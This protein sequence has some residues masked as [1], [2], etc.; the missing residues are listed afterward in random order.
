[1]VLG[2][3]RSRKAFATQARGPEFGTIE[4]S[5]TRGGQGGLPV[6]PASEGG[7]R[8]SPEQSRGDR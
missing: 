2:K 7:D 3:Q 8:E 1:M 6:A 5:D 4:P